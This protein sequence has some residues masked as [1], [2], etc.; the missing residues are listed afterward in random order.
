[1]GIWRLRSTRRVLDRRG[2][3]GHARTLAAGVGM[4]NGGR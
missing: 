2:R 4:R 3:V 1:L